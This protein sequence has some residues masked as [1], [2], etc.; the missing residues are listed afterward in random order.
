MDYKGAIF[1]MDGLLF[2][3]EKVFQQTWH[4]LAKE[5]NVSL[6]DDFAKTICGTVGERLYGVIEH[7]YHVN[8]CAALAQECVERV[9]KKLKKSV[10]V[11]EGAYEILEYFKRKNVKLAIASS[12]VTEQIESNL[13]IT[14]MRRYFDVLVSGTQV[15]RGKP[16]PDIFLYAAERIGCDPK[17][18]YVF[19]DSQNGIKAGYAAGCT[20]VMVPDLVEATSEIRP[21]CSMVWKSLAEFVHYL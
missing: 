15:S 10:P 6:D 1:D 4:E 21:Y 18:C 17:E 19:E 12:S 13:E 3:T 9:M 20:T 5:H 11:K 2:D 14:D 8:D 16:E 7:Y